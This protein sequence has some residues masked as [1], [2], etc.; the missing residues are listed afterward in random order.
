M[1]GFKTLNSDYY[2]NTK[3]KKVSGGKLGSEPKEYIKATVI[4]G[5]PALFYFKDGSF[6]RT[7]DVCGYIM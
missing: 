3:E 4:V 6:M 2:V 5:S 7:S 1:A